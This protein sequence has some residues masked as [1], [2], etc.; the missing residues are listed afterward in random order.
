MWSGPLPTLGDVFQA[1]KVVR[2][3]LKPTPTIESPMLS[4]RMG[5]RVVVKCENL[6]PIGAFKIR[7]GI[8][9]LSTLPEDE[10]AAGVVAASTGN[11]G[12][13]IAYAAQL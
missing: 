12:Q 10:R 4:E 13:S 7:G 11:H 6:Q 8:F 1:R 5:C 3:Y 9:L 2:Q